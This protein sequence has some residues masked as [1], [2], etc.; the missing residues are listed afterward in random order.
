MRSALVSSLVSTT[1]QTGARQPLSRSAPRLVSALG[2][3]K[4]GLREFTAS[5]RALFD[6]SGQIASHRDGVSNMAQTD[7][8][9]P[10]LRI[11][12]IS[13]IQYG[14]EYDL[15]RDALLLFPVYR[16]AGR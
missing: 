1:K 11:G 9:K 3:R 4:A 13:D 8:S 5:P 6:T 16:I 2:A 7:S 14:T 12:V 15:I 10:L